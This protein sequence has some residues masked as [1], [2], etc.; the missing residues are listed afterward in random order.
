MIDDSF[1]RKR[2][3]DP[4]QSF[5][6]QAPA[7]SGKTEL[8]IQRYLKLL[9]RVE[10]PE[11]IVAITFTRKA[12]G[13][14]RAR[15]LEALGMAEAG[16]APESTH[17]AFTLELARA[18]LGRDAM[19]NWGLLQ[20]P[21]RMR[22]QTIDSLC[23]SI[24]RQMPWLARFGAPPEVTEKAA[25][26]YQE[27][28]RNTLGMVQEEERQ[29]EKGPLSTLLLHLDNDFGAA[30]RLIAQMLEKRDQWLRHTGVQPDLDQVRMELERS[31]EKLVACKLAAVAALI[32][33]EAEPDLLRLLERDQM[34]VCESAGMPDWL[35]LADLLLTKGDTPRKQ[36]PKDCPR[37][38]WQNLFDRLAR[39]DG[40]FARLKD[41]RR[42]PAT[43]FD[44]PQWEA[45]EALVDVL[46]KAVAHLQL[47]FG[48]QGRV[49]FAEL[50]IRAL[51]ALG[52]L[53]SPTDLALALG[54]RIEHLL[55]DEFQDT[56]FTQ[57]ELLE[58][59]TSGWHPGEGRT[60]FLVGDP[61]QSI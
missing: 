2:A 22:V 7:G 58:R 10:S 8:L 24:T 38:R 16:S 51:D 57:F 55:I 30:G 27:A 34:P 53:E 29:G 19:G 61:M 44:E 49:D 4:E 46:P 54:H 33:A 13:E 47:V 31:L 11:S 18:A 37:Q 59:L 1:V 39:Q 20:N 48:E 23:A 17:Q 21:A 6:V 5:I 45:V 32:P 3:L 52:R 50:S 26:L 56:S 25:A 12:A 35:S 36:A 14:M 60:L 41:L 43:R 28:A 42:L 40:L 9:A 15:I